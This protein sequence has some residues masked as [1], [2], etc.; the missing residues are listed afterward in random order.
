MTFHIPEAESLANRGYYRRAAN[1]YKLIIRE[2]ALT[3]SE[4]DTA[5]RRFNTLI[6]KAEKARLERAGNLTMN[7]DPDLT[8]FNAVYSGPS[9]VLTF[10][11][12]K[13]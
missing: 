8:A 3:D 5:I 10:W 9:S 11:G 7:Y 4:R 13:P 2:A 1:L 12:C 6:D